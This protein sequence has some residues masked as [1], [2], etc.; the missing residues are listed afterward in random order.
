[1]LNGQWIVHLFTPLLLTTLMLRALLLKAVL[2]TA[3]ALT[4]PSLLAEPLPP[5]Q[6]AP[7]FTL[8]RL[9][10]STFKLSDYKGIKPVYLVFWNS[11][12]SHCMK[13]VP[14]LVKLHRNQHQQIEVLAIN[15]SWSDSLEQ[16]TEFVDRFQASYPIAFDLKAVV[17]DSYQVWGTP[18]DFL[19][20]IDGLIRQVDGSADQLQSYLASLPAA[21]TAVSGCPRKLQPC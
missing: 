14:E 18:T 16:I 15:T 11:W 2:I 6:P 8:K 3:L 19:I 12:C 21:N 4:T 7:D 13:S 17:T 9:D 20:D 1:M 10:G 5:G